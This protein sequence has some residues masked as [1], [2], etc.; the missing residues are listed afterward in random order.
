L[1]NLDD[2]SGFFFGTGDYDKER[3]E[4]DLSFIK[5]AREIIA[6]GDAVYYFAW[7]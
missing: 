6:E 5:M 2:S 3:M 1:G 4:K 7:Y